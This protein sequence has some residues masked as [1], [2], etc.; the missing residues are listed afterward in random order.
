MKQIKKT[1]KVLQITINVVFGLVVAIAFLIATMSLTA[2]SRDIP[3]LFGLSPLQVRTD[4]MTGT[5]NK[6]DLIFVKLVDFD[7]SGK[8]SI[9]FIPGE[10]ILTFKFD[11]NGDNKQD[12]VTHRLIEINNG[13]YVLRGDKDADIVE[14]QYVSSGNILGVY[15]GT[16]IPALGSILAFLQ[17]SAGFLIV[18]VI[19][20][21]LYFIYQGYKLF[22]TTMEVKK[23]NALERATLTEE[24]REAEKKRIRE[25]VLRDL[26]NQ[27]KKDE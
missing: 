13:T 4:S 25:E 21:F 14:R 15:T 9:E 24:Q 26:E 8:P 20:L 7:D 5:I 10:T 11:I 17:S 16:R 22:M 12:I 2:R 19:P 1:K 23:E 18:F 6:G 3:N 27:K